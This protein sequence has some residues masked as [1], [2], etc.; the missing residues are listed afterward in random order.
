M[1]PGSV[2]RVIDDAGHLLIEEKPDEQCPIWILLRL[3]RYRIM[4]GIMELRLAQAAAVFQRSAGFR[5]DSVPLGILTGCKGENDG[6]YSSRF[7]DQMPA[8]WPSENRNH[9]YRL[10]PVLL[11]VWVLS[12]PAEAQAGGLLC[13]LFICHSTLSADSA[14]VRM[15]T[16]S[17]PS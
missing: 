13:L 9:A 2:L 16:S 8:L 15:L 11:R 7:H 10:L 6:R 1:I 17:E 4:P 12:S 14:R 3:R 5:P